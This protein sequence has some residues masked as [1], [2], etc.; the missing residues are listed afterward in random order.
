MQA[1]ATDTSTRRAVSEP[2]KFPPIELENRPRVV[3]EQAAH[4]LNRRPQ[5]L[6][7][8]AMRDGSGPLR[9]IRVHG[10]LA[11]ATADIRNVLGVSQ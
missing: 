9:P 2:Q 6:R 10:R 5:T 11:W 3:T 1:I 8:W 4:Y 7:S